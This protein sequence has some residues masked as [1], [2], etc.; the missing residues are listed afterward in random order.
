VTHGD[1]NA[2]LEHQ[3]IKITAS[4]L[5]RL[6]AITYTEYSMLDLVGDA[7]NTSIYNAFNLL[8]PKSVQTGTGR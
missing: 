2:V 4:E 3:N 6:K 8:Y 7:M 1:I 5:D